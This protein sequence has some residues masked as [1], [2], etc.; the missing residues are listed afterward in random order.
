MKRYL[1]SAILLCISFHAIAQKTVIG[2]SISAAMQRNIKEQREKS[3]NKP[4]LRLY[5]NPANTYTNIY[6]EWIEVKSF[7]IEIFDIQYKTVLLQV[8]VNS[9]KS[10]QYAL[11]VTKLPNGMYKIT[12]KS[13]EQTLEK[14]LTVQH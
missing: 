1:L 6:V 8:P 12:V 9:R 7:T 14:M 11:D 4:S 13:G 3:E 10:Y 5:P 2:D